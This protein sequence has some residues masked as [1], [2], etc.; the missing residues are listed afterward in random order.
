MRTASHARKNHARSHACP[1]GRHLD[2]PLPLLA[3]RHPAAPFQGARNRGAAAWQPDGAAPYTGRPLVATLYR[4]TPLAGNP[5]CIKGFKPLFS[6]DPI[7]ME[8]PLKSSD[9]PLFYYPP[10]HANP[11]LLHP[12]KAW[13]RLPAFSP[14]LGPFRGVCFV[15]IEFGAGF[16]RV[17]ATKTSGTLVYRIFRHKRSGESWDPLPHQ[18]RDPRIEGLQRVSLIELPRSRRDR[19]DIFSASRISSTVGRGRLVFGSVP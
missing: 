4:C 15:S 19:S 12:L 3:D 10:R 11:N 13:S 9:N 17:F 6:I 16:S 7:E 2:A 18:R 14:L 1:P 5:A 8:M